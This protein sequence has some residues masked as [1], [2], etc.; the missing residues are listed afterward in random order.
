MRILPSLFLPCL[1]SIFSFALLLTGCQQPSLQKALFGSCKS[2]QQEQAQK[3]IKDL[4]QRFEISIPSDWK[5]E[6]FIDSSSTRFY[7][8]D[9]T[10]D[11]TDTYIVEIGHYL[12]NTTLDTLFVKKIEDEVLQKEKGVVLQSKRVRLGDKKGYSIHSKYRRLGFEFQ[13]VQSYFP[14]TN[15]SLYILKVEAYGTEKTEARL[16]EGMALLDKALLHER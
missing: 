7:C 6:F 14:N 12:K 9:T 5:K 1:L 13:A 3:N 2:T 10:K 4:H 11:L 15:G 16:C 8:A